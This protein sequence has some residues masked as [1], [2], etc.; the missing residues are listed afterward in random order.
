MVY[1]ANRGILTPLFT[2]GLDGLSERMRKCAPLSW[3]KWK[4]QNH[5]V[6]AESSLLFL[7]GV[8]PFHANPCCPSLSKKWGYSSADAQ[9]LTAAG[10]LTAFLLCVGAAFFFDRFGKRE[11]VASCFSATGTTTTGDAALPCASSFRR[12]PSRR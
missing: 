2:R 6:G 11:Y 9:G 4:V 7:V 3:N 5:L 8:T 10:H 12:P 1:V